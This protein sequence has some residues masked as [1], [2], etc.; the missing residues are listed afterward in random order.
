MNRN[1]FSL[2][3]VAVVLALIGITATVAA[4]SVRSGDAQLR[5][6]VREVRYGLEKAKQEAIARGRNVYVEFFDSPFVHCRK[7]DE[8]FYPCAGPGVTCCALYADTSYGA[9][10]RGGF[11]PEHHEIVECLELPAGRIALVADPPVLRFSPFGGSERV[12]VEMSTEARTYHVLVNHVGGI[13]I[14]DP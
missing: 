7:E 14:K 11:D 5:S 6:Q 4:V 1:G 2:V 8:E 3:E 9:E 10:H 12:Q 13:Q